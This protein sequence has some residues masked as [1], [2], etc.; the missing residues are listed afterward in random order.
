MVES[1]Q[2]IGSNQFQHAMDL[3]AA[4]TE[5]ISGTIDYRQSF[6]KMV[7]LN[8]SIA[9]ES[10]TTLL[11]KSAVGYSFA[12]GT[13]DGPGMFNFTQGTT[14]GNPFW[15]HI[16]DFLSEPTEEEM[17]CQAPKPILFNT[18]DLQQPYDWEPD[19]LSISILRI[20]NLFILAVPAEFT[21][22]SGRRLRKAIHDVISASGIIPSG[23][24]IHVTIAGLAN[25]Y[26]H[27]V[28]TFEEYQAQ[29]YE[30]ASTIYGPYTLDGYIQEFTRY[31]HLCTYCA[32]CKT[33]LFIKNIEFL[34]MQTR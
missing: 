25:G 19:T 32:L 16:R 12:A 10:R 14:S 31:V 20:G 22:M 29:R 17:A 28:T 9:R 3:M 30:A 26:S 33:Y 15:D 27:Y 34:C 2:I 18:G 8:V 4:A 13:T 1:T 6:V 7:G 21:T 5:T 11:C 23:E 24:P